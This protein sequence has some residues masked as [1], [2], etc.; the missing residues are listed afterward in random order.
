MMAAF[1]QA[2]KWP[3]GFVLAEVPDAMNFSW[4]TSPPMLDYQTKHINHFAPFHL[5]FLFSR[6]GFSAL[7]RWTPEFELLNAQCY[8]VLYQADG[9]VGMWERSRAH[10]TQSIAAKVD[11]LRA[12]TEPVIVWGCADITWH[13]LASA[14]NLSIAYFM[15][16]DRRAYEG[17][18]LLGIPVYDSVHSGEPI[19]VMA[20]GQRQKILDNIREL[21]ITNRVIEI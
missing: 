5:D 1:A 18:T 3:G 16:K 4:R 10:V 2:V 19:V 15:D 20:Q 14:P 21:G 13:L 6:F 11:K 17:Q 12:I 7:D 9:L 8:R